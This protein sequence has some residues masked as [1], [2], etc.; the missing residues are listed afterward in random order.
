MLQFS[1]TT[2]RNGII[3]RLENDTNIG[4]AN[5]SGNADLLADFTAIINGY[6]SKATSIIITATGDWTWDDTSHTDQAVA[7]TDIVSGQGD[8]TVLNNTP[9]S[10]KD[11]LRPNRVEIK[12]ENGK[13]TR[14]VKRDIRRYYD[15]ITERRLTGGT[16]TAFDWNGTSVF[17]DQIPNFASIAGLRVWFERAQINF[18]V[19]DTTKRPGFAS[20]FH[21]YLVLGPLYHWEKKNLP[22]KSEQTY[23]DLVTMEEAIKKHYSQRDKTEQPI[24]QREYKRYR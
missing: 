15:S 11:Y 17:L 10:T 9:E 24:L 23:R 12:D 20:I 2:T 22:E 8:Y 16:P 19:A 3:Q 7:T 14:L 13:W 5:I 4:K 18:V 21:E 1:D 6:A